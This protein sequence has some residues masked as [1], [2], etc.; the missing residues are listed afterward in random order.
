MDAE[1][2]PLKKAL[3]ISIIVI[4]IIA[5]VFALV[6]YYPIGVDWEYTYGRLNLADPYSIESFLNPP[7][8]ILFLPHSFLPI[9]LGNMV[10]I[11]LN[12]TVVLF[13]IYK[14]G[15]DWKTIS[16]VFTSPVF[17]DL[18][19]TNN[20]EWLPLLG[21]TIG[22]TLGGILLLCKPQSLGL[23]FLIW[24]K[25]NWKILLLPIGVVLLSFIAWGFWPRDV[26]FNPINTPFNFSVLPLGIPYGIYLLWRAWKEDDEYLAAVS[27]PLFAPYIAP[28]SFVGILTVLGCKYPKAAPWFYF[29]LWAYTIIEFR[30][31]YLSPF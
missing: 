2:P 17:F 21:L 4:C 27:T 12:I 1:I 7:F 28:Y 20:I 29:G 31:K 10:N 13:V 11:F 19:R 8:T 3:F 24:A 9:R 15:G 25:R 30:R 18:C 26:G 6:N 23:V 16:L 14:L 22:P 5:S